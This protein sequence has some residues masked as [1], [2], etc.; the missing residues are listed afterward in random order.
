MSSPEAPTE[1]VMDGQKKMEGNG[2][3]EKMEGKME[4]G[5]AMVPPAQAGEAVAMDAA[6]A[7]GMKASDPA[8]AKPEPQALAAVY[9]DDSADA[10]SR[11]FADGRRV[12]LFFHAAWCP[13]CRN[14]DAAFRARTAELPKDVALLKV[15]YDAA[16][17]L[18]SKYGVTSQHTF[19]Q[20]D[21]DGNAVTKW[22]SGD[23]DMLNTQ[24][25]VK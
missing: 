16:K 3:V 4:S 24:I 8:M 7:A 25:K 21:A 10:R 1:Q 17:D 23:V 9:A 5:G 2:Q 13:Y 11:A 6:A 14:A 20:I 15:D 18:K 12:V 19:V 22:V